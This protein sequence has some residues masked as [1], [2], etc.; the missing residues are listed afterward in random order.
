MSN[1]ASSKYYHSD[2]LY[3]SDVKK[4]FL[5]DFDCNGKNYSTAK[6][7]EPNKS[8]STEASSV[9]KSD[10]EST[11][12]NNVNLT[13]AKIAVLLCNFF[14][15]LNAL[16]VKLLNSYKKDYN[17]N[18]F[19]AIR[20]ITISYVS[21]L[22]LKYKNQEIKSL[23]DIKNWKWFLIRVFSNHMALIFFTLSLF[24][25]RM[26]TNACIY[27]VYPLFT[28]LLSTFFLKEKFQ[29]KYYFA[30][31]ICL[32]GC[33]FFSISEK[34]S[35][36]SSEIAITLDRSTN[37]D[38]TSISNDHL[39]FTIF[40]GILCAALDGL[41]TSVMSI[42]SKFLMYEMN[43]NQANMLIG[44]LLSIIS[45]ITALFSMDS[46]IECILDIGFI[47]YSI[48]NGLVTLGAFYFLNEGV[49]N[50]ELSKTSYVTYCQLVFSVLFGIIFFGEKLL[51][52]DILGFSFIIGTNVYLTFFNI[53]K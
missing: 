30:C 29:I 8:N 18:L 13:Y 37:T 39:G 14:F 17:L 12:E 16:T 1:K 3:N 4:K 31:I 33:I 10:V 48:L 38:N 6:I 20:F 45:L 44:Q 5:E 32:I 9:S 22:F 11:S 47:L 28:N 51:M 27:M 35:N 42:S 7:P 40:L 41:F 24:Y 46:F 36:V 21:Y 26:S 23:F 19:G 34:N 53:K 52:F 43:S 2:K 25:I 15:S 50:A 49:E